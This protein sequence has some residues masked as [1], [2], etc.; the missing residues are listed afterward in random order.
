MSLRSLTRPLSVLAL[1]AGISTAQAVQADEHGSHRNRHDAV[2]S[3][4]D[5]R[6]DHRHGRG[7]DPQ[8]SVSRQAY[9]T[10]G[11]YDQ[12]R[13]RGDSWN[14]QGA[15]WDSRQ[16][17]LHR[18]DANRSYDT[19]RDGSSYGYGDDD[20]RYDSHRY[21]RRGHG[22][23]G[24]NG[25]THGGG[26]YGYNSYGYNAYGYGAAYL[27]TYGY[28]Y[29]GAYYTTNDYGANLLRSAVNYG[30]Q[31]GL[32]IAYQARAASWGYDDYRSCDPY[33]VA[34]YGY[35]P[36]Y[37]DPVQYS[38]YYRVGFERGYREGFYASGPAYVAPPV[39][40]APPAYYGVYRPGPVDLV[41]GVLDVILNLHHLDH[42][43]HYR[44]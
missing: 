15:T 22:H 26:T 9:P 31:Q 28:T 40:N 21:D 11:G 32:A 38:Y 5:S 16:S 20:H 24:Y 34:S 19:R 8:S 30:Y 1:T 6:R 10:R 27:P 41:V 44:H 7:A 25:H 29:G 4:S 2:Q 17:S 3:G 43:D 35:Q 18:D 12:G 42:H 13:S 14:R 33:R 36:G 37:I 39:Y 23:D